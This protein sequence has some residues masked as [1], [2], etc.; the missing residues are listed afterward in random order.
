MKTSRNP[1]RAAALPLSPE[2]IVQAALDEVEAD[3]LAAL[4][5]RKVGQRLGREAMSLYHHFPSKQHL[6][7]AMVDH[8]LRSIEPP[9]PGLSPIDRVR[10]SIYDYRAMAS[11]FPALFPLVAVHR[12]NTPTG[13][14]FIES[15]LVLISAVVPDAETA[16][17]Y[18]RAIGYYI[19]GAGLDESAGYAKGPSAA[20]PVSDEFV[21]RECPQLVGVAPYFKPAHWDATFALGV[22]ALLAAMKRD[23]A[24][25][26]QAS[27]DPGASKGSA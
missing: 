25:L 17:R 22:E 19:T 8:A 20:E 11:R 26:R 7:D 23:A 5:M 18:F 3:G 2:R 16:A 9:P 6:L 1:R 24:R 21:V 13:V 27:R 14:R 12:L 4:S 15:I 10:R